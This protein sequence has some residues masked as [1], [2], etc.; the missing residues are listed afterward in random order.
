MTHIDTSDLGLPLE[1]YTK[2]E[3]WILYF[4]CLLV[5]MI[6]LWLVNIFLKRRGSSLYK[7]LIE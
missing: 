1:T 4:G 5:M 7:W 2:L 3:F 6:S